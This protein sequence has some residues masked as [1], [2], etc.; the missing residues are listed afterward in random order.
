[1]SVPPGLG[2]RT[3]IGQGQGHGQGHGDQTDFFI[4]IIKSTTNTAIGMM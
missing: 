1:M 4:P 3:R 2:T